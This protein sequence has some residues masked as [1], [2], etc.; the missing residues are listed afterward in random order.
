MAIYSF[1]CKIISRTQQTNNAVGKA[2]YINRANMKNEYDGTTWKFENRRDD[3]GY[4]AV[5]LPEN[6]PSRLAD[7]ATL[8]NEVETFNKRKDARLARDFMIALPNELTLEQNKNLVE[9]F[10]K[11]NFTNDGMIANYAIHKDNPTNIHCH[12]MATT[13]EVTV[14]GFAKTNTKGREWN[15][16]D[17]LEQWR[18]GFADKVNEHL[19]KNNIDEKVSHKSLKSQREEQLILASQAQTKED[20]LKH[21]A[22]A[23]KLNRPAQQRATR[24]EYESENIK[25]DRI[26]FKELV[27]KNEIIIDKEVNKKLSNPESNKPAVKNKTETKKRSSKMINILDTIS[28]IYDELKNSVQNVFNPQERRKLPSSPKPK[29]GCGSRKKKKKEDDD[30]N[31]SPIDAVQLRLDEQLKNAPGKDLDND[32]NI[33]KDEVKS[34]R[35]LNKSQ[36]FAVDKE[37]MKFAYNSNNINDFKAILDIPQEKRANAMS[38]SRVKDIEPP[39]TRFNA[40]DKEAKNGFSKFMQDKKDDKANRQ[41][42]AIDKDKNKNNPDKGYNDFAK[43]QNEQKSNRQ[44]DQ[45][46]Q[47]KSS[48]PAPGKKK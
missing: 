9:D 1:Q 12:I 16:K 46:Q 44:N 35:I 41:N 25:A 20:E 6:C 5:L 18:K 17:K 8:W 29:S 4:S 30:F 7:P 39:K 3:V 24:K 22:E 45:Q 47:N 42:A 2:A 34:P 19:A 31:G 27:S 33:D 13:N 14:D 11:D 23:I 28:N 21:I 38:A 37:K 36:Q 26:A 43:K 15:H 32:L 48:S 40:T 10:I